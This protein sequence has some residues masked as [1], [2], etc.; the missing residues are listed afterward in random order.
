MIVVLMTMIYTGSINRSVIDSPTFTQ[1]LFLRKEK[2]PTINTL[3]II[4]QKIKFVI[5]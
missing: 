3:T 2:L 5:I 1:I 4:T